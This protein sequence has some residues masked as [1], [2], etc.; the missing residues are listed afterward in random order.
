MIPS[1]WNRTLWTSVRVLTSI[2]SVNLGFCVFIFLFYLVPDYMAHLVEVQ[3]ER[4]AT[5]G[6]TFHSLLRSS[7]PPDKGW[8]LEWKSG[9]NFNV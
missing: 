2:T 1:H 5:G 7:L 4:G 8:W 9:F 6:H 3:H